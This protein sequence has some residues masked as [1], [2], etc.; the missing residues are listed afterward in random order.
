MLKSVNRIKTEEEKVEQ[1][2]IS[3]N[4]DTYKNEVA[5]LFARP[6]EMPKDLPTA[7]QYFGAWSTSIKS[8]INQMEYKS[9]NKPEFLS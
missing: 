3:L 4:P 8:A 1:F 7:Q 9:Y 5:R 2:M 6:T